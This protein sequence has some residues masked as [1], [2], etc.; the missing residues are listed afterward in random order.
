MFLVLCV[1]AAYAEDGVGGLGGS[2]EVS[3]FEGL[4]HHYNKKIPW[5]F[6]PPKVALWSPTY[7]N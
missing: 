6:G 3:G 2:F 7:A 4:Y 5:I 1:I